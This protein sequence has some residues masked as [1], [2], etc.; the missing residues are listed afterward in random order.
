MPAAFH[1]RPKRVHQAEYDYDLAFIPKRDGRQRLS[2]PCGAFL[3]GKLN[4]GLTQMNTDGGARVCDP[5]Q[6]EKVF[7]SHGPAAHRA[8]FRISDF[9][10]VNPCPSVVKK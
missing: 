5:Q 6:F 9:I 4:H 8:A 3:F 7:C 10:R 1:Y 2:P